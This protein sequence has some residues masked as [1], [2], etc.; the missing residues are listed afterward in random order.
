MDRILILDKDGTLVKPKSGQKFVQH[1]EDQE[2]LPGVYEAIQR[3]MLQGYKI[4]IATN[5]GGV[6]AGYKTLES[7]QEELAYCIKLLG[8]VVSCAALCPDDGSTCLAWFDGTWDTYDRVSAFPYDSFRKP[9]KGMLQLLY[10]QDDLLYVGDRPEDEEAAF[11]MGCE[12]IWAHEFRET[13][14]TQ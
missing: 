4:G 1:P 14:L 12:F 13:G 7:A 3:Y 10:Q 11:D 2:V 6:Q 8:P 9:G 5:Q